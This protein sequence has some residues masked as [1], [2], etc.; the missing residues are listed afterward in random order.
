MQDHLSAV[1]LPIDGL[2]RV[3]ARSVGLPAHPA[4]DGVAGA[5]G[6]HRH[7]VGHDEG[8]VETHAELTDQVGI[9]LFVPGQSVEE[10]PGA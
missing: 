9:G 6:Q 10:C 8:G 4:A 5:A 1:R 2:Q 7:P 3:F